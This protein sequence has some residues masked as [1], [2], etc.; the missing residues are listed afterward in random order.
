MFLRSAAAVFC[1]S[2]PGC[3]VVGYPAPMP[4]PPFPAVADLPAGEPLGAAEVAPPE[5]VEAA[6]ANAPARTYE[7]FGKSYTTRPTAAGYQEV[8]IAS[9]YGERFHGR[10]TASGE[11]YDMHG[12]TAAHRTL[13]FSTCLEVRRTGGGP[14]VIVRVNDRGPFD[15]DQRR[16]VDLSYRAAR[17]IDL[18]APGTA[19]VEVRAL[20]GDDAC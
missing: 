4:P 9:W 10:R 6:F 17:E 8:G 18:V 3:A 11:T 19:E 7:V 14:S 20:P 16:I 15:D 2:A 1:L 13:P 5:P 12:L